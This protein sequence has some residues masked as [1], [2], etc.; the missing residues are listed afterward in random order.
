MLDRLESGLD[1]ERHSCRCDCVYAS[2]SSSL[3]DRIE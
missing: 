2:H 3:A 1:T